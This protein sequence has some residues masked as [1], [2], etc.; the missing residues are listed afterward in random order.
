MALPV[1]AGMIGAQ[2]IGGLMGQNAAKGANDASNRA[3]EAAFNQI[4]GINAPTLTPVQLAELQSTG[5]LSNAMEKDILLGPAA[6][7]G[8]ILDPKARK[9][10]EQAMEQFQQRM[11]TGT[12]PADLAQYELNRRNAAGEAEANSRSIMQNMQARGMGGSGAELIMRLQA[13]QS[14]ADRAAQLGMQQAIASQQAREQAAQNVFSGGSSMRNQDSAEQQYLANARQNVM[15]INNTNRVGTQMRNVAGQNDANRYNV[16]N[17]Q[18]ISD[19]NVGIR[20]QG[21]MY[22]AGLAQQDFGNRMALGNA[23]A[24][25][26]NGQASHYAQQ[27]QNQAAMYGGFGQAVSNGL[28]AWGQQ[29]QF[30]QMMKK[31]G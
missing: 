17:T 29:N 23:K 13:G 12:T 6:A 19:S 5:Q 9:A 20:N 27:A 7:E 26:L 16:A 14:G 28:G 10:Q 31:L 18:R 15:N 3:R 25:A 1:I 30:D 22:N 24:N 11:L 8:I 2:I 4:S 21:T